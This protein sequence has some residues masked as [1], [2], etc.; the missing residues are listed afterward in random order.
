ML[1]GNEGRIY[2]KDGRFN[3]SERRC[4]IL[5]YGTVG[6][7]KVHILDEKI[8]FKEYLEI[9]KKPLFSL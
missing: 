2:Y 4:V 1:L 9:D 5:G 7:I 8:K 6:P 3:A